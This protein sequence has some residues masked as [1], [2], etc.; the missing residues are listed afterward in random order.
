[1]SVRLKP[2]IGAAVI[3]VIASASANAALLNAYEFD[4]DLSDSVGAGP[5]L[6]S[7]G[8]DVSGGSFVFGANQGLRLTNG[9]ADTS[10]FA[11]E[12]LWRGHQPTAFNFM[13]LIDF[14]NLTSDAGLYAEKFLARFNYLPRVGDFNAFGSFTEDQD[15]LV[16]FER[17]DNQARVFID[18][19]LA[20]TKALNPGESVPAGNILH[21]FVDDTLSRIR[22]NSESIEGSVDFIRFHEDASTFSSVSSVPI[23]AAAPLLIAGV[24]LLFG[25]GRK[26]KTARK[27]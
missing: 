14:Q 10:N 21:F 5:D 27:G 3:S 9:L 6:V 2:V 17:N 22:Q 1:M 4:G 19:E 13:K 25:L 26:R 24:G 8:G 12:F 18:G 16:G 11:I 20:L 15:Y 7:L 23:P